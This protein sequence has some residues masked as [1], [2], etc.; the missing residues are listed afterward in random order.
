[1]ISKLYRKFLPA[2]TISVIATVSF[3]QTTKPDSVITPASTKYQVTAPLRT[4]FIG[5][6]YR[7][8][9]LQPVKVAVLD[10]KKEQGGLAIVD[11][12]GG[13]QTNNLR[14]VDKAGNE[15]T[16]RQV[17]KD[18]EK[19]MLKPLKNTIIETIMQDFQTGLHPYAAL[20]VPVLARAVG[21]R[22]SKP[23]LFYLKDDPALGIHRPV[24][25][26]TVCIL[27][28]REPT[29]DHSDTRSTNTMVEK[30]SSETDHRLMQKVML[31]ARLLDMLI[32]DW[33]RHGDQWRWEMR[34]SAG[35]RY[36]YPIP[37]DRDYAYFRSNGWFMKM[38]STFF[39]P[40]MRGF[41]R[42]ANGLKRL[43]SKVLYLDRQWLDELSA[44]DWKE[45]IAAFQKSITDSVI[46]KAIKQMPVEVYFLS[47]KKIASMLRSRRDSLMKHA[48]KY[49]EFLA[50][51]RRHVC[52]NAAV[53]VKD[54]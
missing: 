25:A 20:T 45:T 37:R 11:S 41:S 33:D 34:D 18:I 1:M 22:T 3:G 6:N 52:R 7:K 51:G 35:V 13:R 31:R 54:K 5:T 30:I 16:L 10:L 2:F 39:Q 44:E 42:N 19:S 43:N 24:F 12:G 27:E 8:E 15:W 29:P 9:W 14:L 50:S 48:M 49:Y 36:Y 28:E 47:G 4:L 26:N 17:D 23:K 38:M 46:D 40:H 53:F 21:V 32:G